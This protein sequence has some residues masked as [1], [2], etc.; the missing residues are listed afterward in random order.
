MR[1]ND[2]YHTWEIRKVHKNFGSEVLKG[3]DRLGDIGSGGRIILK[4]MLKNRMWGCGV[5]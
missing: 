2:I 4:L 5:D 1:Q 3:G